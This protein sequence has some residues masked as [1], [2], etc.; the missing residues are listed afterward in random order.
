MR[1]TSSFR[2]QWSVVFRAVVMAALASRASAQGW[3]TGLVSPA[4]PAPGNQEYISGGIDTAI[5]ATGDPGQSYCL[6]LALN[7]V[8]GP[9]GT[10]VEIWCDNGLGQ[11]VR[12][13]QVP[14]FRTGA[15]AIDG[16]KW[17][18]SDLDQGPTWYG[19]IDGSHEQAST[20]AAPSLSVSHYSDGSPLLVHG[21]LPPNNHVYIT[22]KNGP[23]WTTAQLTN[24]FT[25]ENAL[26]KTIAAVIAAD[27]L[28]IAYWD[29]THSAVRY[30]RK[31]PGENW[32]FETVFSVSQAPFDLWPSIGVASEG[33]PSIVFPM[34]DG[35]IRVFDRLP[36]GGWTQE[37]LGDP[38]G[39]A[40]V[41][42]KIALDS[43]R[44]R[45]HL[46]YL[47]YD[48]SSN[49]TQIRYRT[50]TF[51]NW[52][53]PEQVSTATGMDILF[54]LSMDLPS[55]LGPAAGPQIGYLLEPFFGIAFH[56]QRVNP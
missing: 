6:G 19:T 52:S 28:H 30:A 9:F 43:R 49:T 3:S 12:K 16:M 22:T 55:V 1:R 32:L 10:G 37:T 39:A 23:T 2:S 15:V 40:V 14:V 21:G 8:L 20:V 11:V 26:F 36:G 27:T 47:T 53:A 31:A 7:D 34:Y 25:S 42:R 29:A 17:A 41:Y 4:P 50:R 18:A 46:L 54:G 48:T 24:N 44:S 13:N 45:L 51:G 35:T 33:R 5:V 38:A 56:G